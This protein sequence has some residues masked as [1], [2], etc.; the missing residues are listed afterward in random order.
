MAAPVVSATVAL[1]L[2]AA[3]SLT[4]NAV[5]AILQYTAQIRPNTSPLAQGAGLINARGALRLARFFAHPQ[6][7]PLGQP[8]DTLA[9]EPITWAR[10]LIWGNYR[11]TGG[12]PLP[13]SNAW[14]TNVVWG[15]SHTPAGALVVWGAASPDNVVWGESTAGNVVWGELTGDN[16][17]WGESGANNVVWGE[18]HGDNVVWG[19]AHSDNVVWGEDCNGSNCEQVIWGTP[20]ATGAWG[21]ALATD[22]VVWGE[23]IPDNVVWGES[24]NVVWGEER[25]DFEVVWPPPA[26]EPLP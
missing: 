20:N 16:V 1:M 9:S 12:V 14:A 23:G 4:P 3:P 19:E 13:G 22:N 17:V 7:A 6:T 21:T 10:H 18:A 25:G 5:K 2:E 11:V 8:V 24:I 15:E 26:V